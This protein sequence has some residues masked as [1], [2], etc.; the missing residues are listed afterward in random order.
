MTFSWCPCSLLKRCRRTVLI[1]EDDES[2]RA[3]IQRRTMVLEQKTKR[4]FDVMTK[5]DESKNVESKAVSKPARRKKS[6]KDR[7]LKQIFIPYDI[8]DNT[9][10]LD[11]AGVNITT[12]KIRYAL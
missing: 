8:Y 4:L 10:Y 11:A 9:I 5:V 12:E 3:M 7:L 6:I 1:Q 2:V